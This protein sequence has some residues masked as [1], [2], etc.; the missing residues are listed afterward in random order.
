[1]CIRDSMRSVVLDEQKANMCGICGAKE[2]FIEYK[3]LE[4]IHFIWC[5]K[6]HTITFF[7]QP[8]SDDKKR[9]IEN[10]M[11]FYKTDLKK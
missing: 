9:L 7:K 11:N 6:C 8:Q 2:P 4:D 3:Q 10:E 1:M 5:N